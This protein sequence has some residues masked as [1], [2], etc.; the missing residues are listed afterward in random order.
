MTFPVLG[1]LDREPSREC[2]RVAV[3]VR[4]NHRTVGKP[5]QAF[6]RG[7]VVSAATGAAVPTVTFSGRGK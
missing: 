2:R 6:D 5:L 4:D 7:A 3:F 1:L